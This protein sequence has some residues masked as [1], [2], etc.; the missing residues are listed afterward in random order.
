MA[1]DVFEDEI[2]MAGPEDVW[3][4]FSGSS[5]VT[6]L[7]HQ[8]LHCSLGLS[9][10]AEAPTCSDVLSDLVCCSLKLR[11]LYFLYSGE[12]PALLR[13]LKET[14]LITTHKSFHR[15]GRSV[16]YLPTPAPLLNSLWSALGG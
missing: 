1:A 15:E 13:Y 10:A 3:E 7:Y 11:A 14:N 9:R 8:L 2:R 5:G 6:M 12:G 16:L 4:M